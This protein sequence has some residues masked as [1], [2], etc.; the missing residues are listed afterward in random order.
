MHSASG[1]VMCYRFCC[2]SVRLARLA[3][4]RDCVGTTVVIDDARSGGSSLSPRVVQEQI[5]NVASLRKMAMF[6][7]RV[8]GVSVVRR[9]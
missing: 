7:H 2:F 8:P 3:P 9:T 4:R 1:W 6:Y 5:D